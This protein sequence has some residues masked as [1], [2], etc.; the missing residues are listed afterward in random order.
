MEREL[1]IYEMS[2]AANPV[3]LVLSRLLNYRFPR[4]YA[5][6]RARRSINLKAGQHSNDEL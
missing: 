1:R 5:A 6:T 2:E 4:E 3:S